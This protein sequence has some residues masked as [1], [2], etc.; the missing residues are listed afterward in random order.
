MTH[1][2]DLLSLEENVKV[3]LTLVHKHWIHFAEYY[4]DKYVTHFLAGKPWLSPLG[5][6][7]RK[8]KPK[9]IQRD[10]E[11][12]TFL[13]FSLGSLTAFLWKFH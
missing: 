10:K 2:F 1:I 12:E 3:W 9:D 5:R 8:A 6:D 11:V 13:P 4:L 7:G